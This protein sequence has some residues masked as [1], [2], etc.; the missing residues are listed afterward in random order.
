MEGMAGADGIPAGRFRLMN[1]FSNWRNRR[2]RRHR[3]PEMKNANKLGSVI[4]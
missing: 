1:D 3:R 2:H 4:N